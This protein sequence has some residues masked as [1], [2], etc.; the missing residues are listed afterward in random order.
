M[1]IKSSTGDDVVTETMADRLRSVQLEPWK[2]MEFVEEDAADTWDIYSQTLLMRTEDG[3]IPDL[4]GKGKGKELAADEAVGVQVGNAGAD[5]LNELVP[6]LGTD[7]GEDELL[8]AVSGIGKGDKKPGEEAVTE[9]EKKLKTQKK[10][11]P[12]VKPE[13]T[14]PTRTR[15]ARARRPAPAAATRRGGKSAAPS[16][17]MDVDGA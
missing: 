4:E 1:T 6:G 9:P 2:K 14:S 5:T 8:R 10:I 15:T 12:V 17:A 11:E 16:S 13:A 7:W 3:Q